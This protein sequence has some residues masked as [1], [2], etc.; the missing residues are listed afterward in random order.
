MSR[1]LVYALAPLL[2][3]PFLTDS[4]IIPFI[5]RLLGKDAGVILRS[6]KGKSMGSTGNRGRV[7]RWLDM[8]WAFLE[9]VFLFKFINT[10]KCIKCD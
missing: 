9:V 1:T 8:L 10:L 6:N 7:V 4:C 5:E 3:L 2:A